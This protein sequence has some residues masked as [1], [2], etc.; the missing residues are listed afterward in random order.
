[1]KKIEKLGTPLTRKQ[2]QKIVGGNNCC[3]RV[4]VDGLGVNIVE[5]CGLS[6][7]E[8]KALASQWASIVD[9]GNQDPSVGGSWCCNS[10]NV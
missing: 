1:M 9:P 4:Y 6:M 2:A 10:C 5:T 8:A 3:A 7:A